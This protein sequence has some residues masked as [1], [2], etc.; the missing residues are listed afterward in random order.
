MGKEILKAIV[1]A[2]GT[3]IDTKAAED[4]YNWLTKKE[5]KDGKQES[6]GEKKEGQGRSEG[7]KEE[8]KLSAL[9]PEG[10]SHRQKAE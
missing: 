3:A 6:K 10:R 7:S 9:W 5:K 2:F 4:L 8:S 1:I